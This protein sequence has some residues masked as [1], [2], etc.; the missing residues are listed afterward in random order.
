MQKLKN[1]LLIHTDGNTFNNPTLK[2]VVDLLLEKGVKV[3]I[4]YPH[5]IAPMPEIIG[6]TLLPFNIWYRK[7]KNVIFNII[8]WEWLSRFSVWL[9]H[10]CLYKD[11]DLIIGVDRRGLIEAYHLHK[12]SNTPFVFFSF[13]IMFSSETS[14]RYKA[15]EIFA[16]RYVK[17]W[18]VQDELRAKHLEI[19]NGLDSTTKTLIPLASS[20]HPSPETRR[21]RD[22]L[23]IPVEKKVAIA[24]GS[25]SN[26][27]MTPDIIATVHSWPEEWVL[28]IHDRY[29]RTELELEKIGCDPSSL[30]DRVYISRLSPTSVDDMSDILAGVSVGLAFY[31]PVFTSPYTGNNMKY[32]GISS[33]KISTFL[34]HEIPII[35]NEIGMYSDFARK[36]GFGIVV[37]DVKKIGSSLDLLTHP[38][39]RQNAKSFYLEYLNFEIYQDMVWEGFQQAVNNQQRQ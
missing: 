24:I 30:N 28:I 25:I 11:Y 16:S 13:E 38:T 21:L 32:I 9:E 23:G 33:G 39:M 34:R 3:T 17:H 18:F 4:R 35:L 37:D 19:E 15:A 8:C 14:S 1:V 26:W 5:S 7:I 6:L 10:I 29:G 20:G 27:S 36:Y 31:K 12:I 2:C 22:Y